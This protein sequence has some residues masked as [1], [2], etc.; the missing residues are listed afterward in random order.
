MQRLRWDIRL[1]PRSKLL[2]I[3]IVAALSCAT[4]AVAA[5]VY[6]SP[7]DD[8][9]PAAGP[10]QISE[11]GVQSVY[12]YIDGGTSASAGGTACA[13]GS[14]SELCG[15]TLTLTGLAGVDPSSECVIENFG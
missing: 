1:H 5:Q 4:P 15:Y 11:G 8:G 13:T 2:G 6:H 12:L 7:N 9:Q 14:G 10:P 3:A